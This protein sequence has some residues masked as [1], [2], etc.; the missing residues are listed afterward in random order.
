MGARY[1]NR[2][3]VTKTPR[4]VETDPKAFV[5]QRTPSDALFVRS[6]GAVPRIRAA[7]W[8]L[9]IAGEVRR[10]L[11]LTLQ[12]LRRMDTRR[13]ELVLECAGNGRARFS[14]P[15]PGVAWGDGAVGCAVFE[16]VALRTLLARAGVRRGVQEIVFTGADLDAQGASFERSL[17]LAQAKRPQIL[18]AWGMNGRALDDEHGGPVRLVVPGH[19][20]V[21][22]V[23]WLG[24]IEARRAPLQAKYQTDHYTVRTRKGQ[25]GRPI[26]ALRVN[27]RIVGPAANA[28][29]AVGRP[30]RI[31]GWAW[32]GDDGVR[33]VDVSTD[34]GATWRRARLGTRAPRHAWRRWEL[35]WTPRKAAA[36]T[37][38]SRA[39][40]ARGAKQP[41]RPVWNLGGYENNA[42]HI[43]RL[44]ASRPPKAKRGA[45][46]KAWRAEPPAR[47]P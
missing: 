42:V 26:F 44:R 22:S 4:N 20:G 19:Y 17:A 12:D 27:S 25:P 13:V 5:L 47:R 30:T 1:W 34:A 8:V 2:P 3:V 14:P 15:A 41:L 46:R 28:Q 16:G 40:D 36:V 33:Q 23:K 9:R 29:L 35:G 38:M 43:V 18:V 45:R 21:A 37:L 39:I 10:P 31:W 24:S 11:M 6:H 7:D 32:G